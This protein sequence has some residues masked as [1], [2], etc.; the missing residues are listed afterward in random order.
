MKKLLTVTLLSALI[1]SLGFNGMQ[2][3]HA[4]PSSEE[5]ELLM[6]KAEAEKQ[7]IRF[8]EDDLFCLGVVIYQEAGGDLA[9]DYHRMMVGNVVLNRVKSPLFPNSIR[10]VAEGQWQYG[11]L[12]ITG[13]VLPER[14]KNPLEE[15]AV[16]RSF[17]V[18][19]RLLEGERVCPDNI[20]FQAEFPQGDYIY[21]EIDGT[22]FCGINK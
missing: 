15:E 21:E 5:S 14:A 17:D 6:M 2:V 7:K 10:E 1:L 3:S 16:K 19:R 8:T 20:L 9:S 22:Y 4:E 13:V 18:A 12:W 11:T